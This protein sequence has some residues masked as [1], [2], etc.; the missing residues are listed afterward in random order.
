QH[1]GEGP[2][3]A[4]LAPRRPPPHGVVGPGVHRPRLPSA[5]VE[6]GDV[7]AVAAREH[8]VGIILARRD[9]A[10]LAAAHLVP[11]L[12]GDTQPVGAARDAD[13][14]VVLLRTAPPVR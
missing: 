3:A 13:R 12:V 9:P 5:P 1:D 4:L 6:A 14:A 7:A 2:L 10:A 11:V 8:H